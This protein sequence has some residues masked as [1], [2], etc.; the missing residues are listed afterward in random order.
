MDS[1][2]PEQL[3]SVPNDPVYNWAAL[4][5][6][7][8]GF[9]PSLLKIWMSEYECWKHHY[10]RFRDHEH[11]TLFKAVEGTDMAPKPN[12][13]VMRFHRRAL[14]ALLQSGEQCA[15]LLD[16]LKLENEEAQERLVL[17][18]RIKILL[19]SLQ[20]TL[21]LWHPVNTESIERRTAI[22]KD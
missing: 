5:K 8:E 13:Q 10:R 16:K 22:L 20:E 3:F 17:Q 4:A 2:A 6:E 9:K 14:F 12:E 21:E 11:V 15:E 7:L 1:A 18:R 19:E